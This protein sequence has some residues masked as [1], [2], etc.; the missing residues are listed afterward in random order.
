MAKVASCCCCSVDVARP[1]RAKQ[2][3]LACRTSDVLGVH[4]FDT[5]GTLWIVQC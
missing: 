5:D 1:K 4:Y 3:E 2:K